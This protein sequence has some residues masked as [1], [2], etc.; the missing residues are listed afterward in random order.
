MAIW[1][2]P[3]VFNLIIKTC[4]YSDVEPWAQ[5]ADSAVNVFVDALLS[6]GPLASPELADRLLQM[7]VV[8]TEL[9]GSHHHVQGLQNHVLM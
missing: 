5:P 8:Q 6:L 4:R 2:M 3:T 7:H 1:M 9:H